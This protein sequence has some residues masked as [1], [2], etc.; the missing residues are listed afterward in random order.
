MEQPLLLPVGVLVLRYWDKQFNVFLVRV[1]QVLTKTNFTVHICS[2]RKRFS[3]SYKRII[4]QQ[5]YNVLIT[6]I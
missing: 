2:E 6:S 5:L 4:C 1:S 3:N